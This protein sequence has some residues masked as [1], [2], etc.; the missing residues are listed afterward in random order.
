MNGDASSLAAQIVAAY[1]SH[2]EISP[3]E[4][5]EL[6]RS[7]RTE[8]NTDGGVVNVLPVARIKPEAL[9]PA[10]S[11]EH[12]IQLDALVCLECGAA[13]KLLKSH[14]RYRHNLWP[15]QYAERWGLPADYPFVAAELSSKR[16]S[17][18]LVSGL[19]KTDHVRHPARPPRL[20]GKGAPAGVEFKTVSL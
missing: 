20:S 6:L 16:R 9:R 2:N 13:V 5:V 17:V 18:A 7:L 12:S 19:G 1:V 14:I 4:V 15:Q 11:V 10:V 3:R 8:L